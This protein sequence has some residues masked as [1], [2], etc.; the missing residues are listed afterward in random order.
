MNDQ[1]MNWISI[2]SDIQRAI[3][4]SVGVHLLSGDFLENLN[5][6]KGVFEQLASTFKAT[7]HS[8]DK[9]ISLLCKSK[10]NNKLL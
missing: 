10:E 8:K 4:N 2:A 3:D 9:V 5:F 6:E 7:L 1:S